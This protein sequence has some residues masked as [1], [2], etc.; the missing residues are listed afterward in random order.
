M[1]INTDALPAPPALT[2][3]TLCRSRMLPPSAYLRDGMAPSYSLYNSTDSIQST[4]LLRCHFHVSDST[5]AIRSTCICYRSSC[6]E[7]RYLNATRPGYFPTTFLHFPDIFLTF[8]CHFLAIFLLLS[9]HSPPIC[10]WQQNGDAQ[11]TVTAV[12]TRRNVAS[13]AISPPFQRRRS[14]RRSD[15]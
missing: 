6:D 4:R 13:C 5:L 2:N 14:F 7:T 11:H 10:W 12:S 9:C 1:E 8:S 15:E 3:S